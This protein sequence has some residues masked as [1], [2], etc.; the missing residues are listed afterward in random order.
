MLKKLTSW[1]KGNNQTIKIEDIGGVLYPSKESIISLHDHIIKELRLEDEEVHEGTIS[2]G[3]LSF[4]GVKYY[5]KESGDRRKDLLLRG[6][7]IFNKFLQAGHPFVDGNKRTGFVTLWLFLLL[8]KLELEL[9]LQS[10]QSQVVK[11]N[12][13]ADNIEK[14]NISEIY[15]WLDKNCK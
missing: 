5:F 2:D 15:S 14:D 1:I 9:P 12:K 3:V 7:N 10:Y 4:H 6:A 13:W 8:N 11:I